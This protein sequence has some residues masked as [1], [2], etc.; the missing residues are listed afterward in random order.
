MAKLTFKVWATICIGMA[1]Q[2]GAV[3]VVATFG[4]A[5][6]HLVDTTIKPLELN[7]VWGVFLGGAVVK[8]ATYLQKQPMPTWTG[9]TE[10]TE[11]DKNG[12]NPKV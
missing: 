4:L 7:Q 10:V 12:T 9:D 1:V 6:A 3:S 5:A 2:G 8:I 11:K